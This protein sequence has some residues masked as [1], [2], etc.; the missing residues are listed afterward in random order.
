MIKVDFKDKKLPMLGLGTMRFPLIEGS[1]NPADIDI[2][3]T[4]EIIDLAMSCGVN[5]FDTAYPYHGSQSEI[6]L[7]KLLAK[8]P[9]DSYFLATKFPGHQILST[10]DPKA[11]F[12]DQLK[13]CN[14]EY[15][16]FY[17]LHNVYENSINT[18]TDP[19]WGIID[20]F[21][22]QK[23]EGRIK[24]L[25]FSTHSEAGFLEKFLEKYGD[26]MEFCQIQLNYLDWTLQDA[27]RKCEILA[28]H[29]IPVWV[30]EPVRGGKLANL[31][32]EDTALLRSVNSERTNAEWAFRWLQGIDNVAVI[33]SGMTTLD[34]LKENICTFSEIKK[35]NEEELRALETIAEKMKNTVPCTSCRYCTEG[36]P[37]E[38]NIPEMLA[39]Y[40]EIC[41]APTFNIGM[42]MDA[43]PVGKRA[44]D[45]IGC[46]QCTSICP[47]GIDIPAA[48]A[49]FVV[50]LD[51]LPKWADICRERE[52]AA[53]KAK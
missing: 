11:V 37:M 47:Q 15:F 6:V 31:S 20:Y 21:V 23:R 10:Y 34:Q 51:K 19:K 29:N 52:L 41:F 9:R 22:Q 53:K 14:V 8:Y 26:I 45:C 33:L 46:N 40:N 44:A 27:K 25:G 24:H 18:Y 17:L 38:I 43:V 50:R 4:E 3:K 2:K 28:K 36:C 35:L 48:L 16:D 42:R 49:D 39:N 30:M 5:Y 1:A 13:K 32:V 12:E 7:G